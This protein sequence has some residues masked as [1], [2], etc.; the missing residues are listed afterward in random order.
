MNKEQRSAING[1]I[2][3]IVDVVKAWRK[4]KKITLSKVDIIYIV[5]RTTDALFELFMEDDNG[6]EE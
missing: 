2:D 5:K 3:K 1:L 6:Q 4:S